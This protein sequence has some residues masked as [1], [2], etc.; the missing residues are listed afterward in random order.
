MMLELTVCD[1][2]VDDISNYATLDEH[3]VSADTREIW[4]NDPSG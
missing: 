3:E 2:S 4:R 1:I